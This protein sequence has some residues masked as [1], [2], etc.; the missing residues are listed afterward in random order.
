MFE[1][2][3]D[4]RSTSINSLFATYSH[5]SNLYS[6]IEQFVRF[7]RASYATAETSLLRNCVVLC[8]RL[9]L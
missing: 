2:R 6:R 4:S 5:H 1:M 8:D 7:L 9:R 3:T